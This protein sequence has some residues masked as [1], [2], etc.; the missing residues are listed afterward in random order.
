MRYKTAHKSKLSEDTSV[1]ATSGFEETSLGS[2]YATCCMER[3]CHR[4]KIAKKKKGEMSI[5][6]TE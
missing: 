5:T 1:E 3:M 4:N 6:S 2:I